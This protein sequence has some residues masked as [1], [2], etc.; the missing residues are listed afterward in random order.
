MA[1]PDTASDSTNAAED[2][3]EELQVMKALAGYRMVEEIVAE[4]DNGPL[5]LLYMTNKQAMEVSKNEHSMNL[6]IDA[7]CGKRKKKSSLIIDLVHSWGFKESTKLME[8]E[9]FLNEYSK[10][11]AG[12]GHDTAPFTD[13]NDELK[14]H[15]QLEHFMQTI[16]IPLAEQTSA[17]VI[18]NAVSNDC[19]LS[20]TFTKMVELKLS[21][22]NGNPPFTVLAA[23]GS[24]D[25]LYKNPNSDLIWEKIMNS[26]QHWKKRH[27]AVL[28]DYFED[29]KKKNDEG[30]NLYNRYHDLNWR[31]RNILI[32]EGFNISTYKKIGQRS[33]APFSNLMTTLM[34]V[35]GNKVP[36]LAIKTGATVRVRTDNK[37]PRG[38]DTMSLQMLTERA[39]AGTKVLCLDI[40]ERAE[41]AVA[42]VDFDDIKQKV[43]E[44]LANMQKQ[45]NEG[46]TSCESL[47]SSILAYLH[48]LLNPRLKEKKK[49]EENG[50]Q[51]KKVTLNEALEAEKGNTF[52]N[53]TAEHAKYAIMFATRFYKNIL[54]VSKERGFYQE[55]MES[56]Q[57]NNPDSF[58]DAKS[59]SD[60]SEVNVVARSQETQMPSTEM[61]ILQK[62]FGG[63]IQSTATYVRALLMSPNFY[64]LN[65]WD[66]NAEK[67][68]K[69]DIVLTG[70]HV[71][72]T[73]EGL[74]LLKDA[75]DS[76]D[77]THIA[78]DQFKNLCK[79]SYA[80][81]L[82]LGILI[83]VFSVAGVNWSS[84]NEVTEI[85]LKR[86]TLVS[87]LLLAA[88]VSMDTMFAPRSNWLHLRI[89]AV[90]LESIIW[91]FRM[92]AG[93]FKVDIN[94]LNIRLAEG[95][96]KEALQ[97]WKNQL[98][99]GA[100]VAS[101]TALHGEL[102]KSKKAKFK[103]KSHY[104]QDCLD[105]HYSPLNGKEYIDLRV[106]KIIESYKKEIPKNL[107]MQYY[108]QIL[109]IILGVVIAVFAELGLASIVT[110]LIAFV[111]AYNSWIEFNGWTRK[112]QLYTNAISACEIE[113]TEWKG[114]TSFMVQDKE[115]V[116]DFVVKIED[117][118]MQV[119]QS[120]STTIADKST[121]ETAAVRYKK[122]R[123]DFISEV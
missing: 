55:V 53:S 44:A 87:S 26:S 13:F 76:V 83:T 77:V 37:T 19:V 84:G 46:Y 54:D 50:P 123:D 47:D 20:D 11:C 114:H 10:F 72:T 91:K 23:L 120:W 100:N 7:L 93:E 75:W 103:F 39:N 92:R 60:E 15:G 1:T 28:K 106:N 48:T 105:D 65:I 27:E 95:N 58:P 70:T 101:L 33:R 104:I 86:A 59:R 38:I 35:I 57:I 74:E 18:C 67:F 71:K 42:R 68:V 109:V 12:I 43:I 31:T 17:I 108:P 80:I 61:D 52:R 89:H 66:A 49:S 64:S 69:D 51:D 36:S 56:A 3:D 122:E 90:M 14:T 121:P 4:H 96:F 73:H 62:I 32:I 113:H 9:T 22:W 79:I 41:P 16:I 81:Q 85:L 82:F 21:K 8:R 97:D 5:N 2:I 116:N 30:S 78:A 88:V 25:V 119:V 107:W 98:N 63:E 112:A 45:H 40:R 118:V 24:V 110:I 99:S 29:Q 34:R 111:S 117:I 94:D 115:L 6:M 102:G